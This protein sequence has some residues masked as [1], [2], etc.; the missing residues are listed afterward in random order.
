MDC[1]TVVEQLA[2]TLRHEQDE[3]RVGLLQEQVEEMHR[4]KES[5]Q[6]VVEQCRLVEE[7]WEQ[8]ARANDTILVRR[9]H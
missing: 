7:L 9:E 4:K 6:Q 5:D 1:C 3:E 8:L 2:E